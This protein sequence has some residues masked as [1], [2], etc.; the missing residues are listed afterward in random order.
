[1]KKEES[2]HESYADLHEIKSGSDRS[3][4]IVF[5]IVFLII[6]LFPLK[7]GGDVRWWAVIISAGFSVA[8]LACPKCLSSLNKLWFRFG[9]LLQKIV[10]PIIMGIL[11][12]GV[13]TPTAFLVRM[14]GKDILRLKSEPE[15][16]SYWIIRNPPGPKPETMK[17]QF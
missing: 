14:M 17:D 6:A 8:A 16:K 1:M 5:A 4:G 11:F 10:N 2:F 7:G 9:L 15:Q 13:A 12:Y 3:F